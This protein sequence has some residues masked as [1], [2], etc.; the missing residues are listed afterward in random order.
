M[1]CGGAALSLGM[2]DLTI[3]YQSLVLG[4]VIGKGG[5]GFVRRGTYNG[6]DIAA[7]VIVENRC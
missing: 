6:M 7:K 1:Y 4:P 5:S 2:G 3:E